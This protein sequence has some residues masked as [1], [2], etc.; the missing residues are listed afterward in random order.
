MQE[1]AR[2]SGSSE[3]SPNNY[4]A[5]SLNMKREFSKDKKAHDEGESWA[6]IGRFFREYHWL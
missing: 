3:Y 2:K 4:T 6:T 1:A 5:L